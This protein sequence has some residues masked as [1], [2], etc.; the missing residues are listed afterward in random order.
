MKANWKSKGTETRISP[1]LTIVNFTLIT[2]PRT[3]SIGWCV[4]GHGEPVTGFAAARSV[5]LRSGTQHTGLEI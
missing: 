3:Q 1:F 4:R 5:D 2:F